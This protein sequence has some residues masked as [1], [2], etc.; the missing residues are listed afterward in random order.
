MF[1]LELNLNWT[2]V[3]HIVI[4]IVIIIIGVIILIPP[5]LVGKDLGFPL[6]FNGGRCHGGRCPAHSRL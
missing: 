3:T 5:N 6:L 4:C 1:I 2:I